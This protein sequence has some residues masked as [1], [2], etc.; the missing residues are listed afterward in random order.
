MIVKYFSEGY[1]ACERGDVVE[2]NPYHAQSGPGK[3]WDM[4][5]HD[6]WYEEKL[7]NGDFND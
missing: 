2:E 5:W 7:L 3:S 1:R 6:R 4:G